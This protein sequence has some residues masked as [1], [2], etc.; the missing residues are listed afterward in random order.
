MSNSE[1]GETRI[2]VYELKIGMRVSRL[3]V[4]NNESPFLFDVIEIKSSADIQAIQKICDYVFIDVGR[5]KSQ[6][7]DIPTR[8]SD[9]IKQL[10]FARSFK[11]TSNVFHQ[12]GALIKTV[13]DDIRFGN[14]FSVEAV[15]TAV[16]QTVDQVL[17][18]KDAMLLLT[19]LKNQD[20]Y[21][22]QHSMNV[23]VLS[24]LLGRELKLSVKELNDLGLCGL[25]H[26][27]G[28]MK[29]PLEILNKPGKL[30]DKELII[31]RK[32]TDFGRNVLISARNL[33]PGAVDVAYSHHERIEGG[34]YP[35]GVDS[36]ALS[37]FTKIVT[38]VDTYDAITSDRVYQTGQSH[39]VA[40]GILVK[41]MNTQFESNYITQFINC[42]GFYPQGNLVELSNGEA[43]LVIEQNKTDRLKP[44]LLIVL[45]ENKNPTDRKILDLAS[46]PLDVNNQPYRIKQILKARDYG[47]DLIKF[48]EENAFTK[49]YPSIV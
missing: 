3:E 8:S 46:K 37:V 45:D 17:E 35:R 16:S 26:D 20:E 22:A 11:Q 10:S 23:C 32:H 14:Q 38:V 5:Q 41:G 21:T 13:L 27:V 44:K 24:I 48:H 7:G 47:I 31:M 34:G 6:H 1:N 2:H 49:Y 30:E 25:L 28:K 40:L 33:Y 12:T 29:V 39:L 43:A 36:S 42:I 9:S 15:K 19:Q 18:N 4:L